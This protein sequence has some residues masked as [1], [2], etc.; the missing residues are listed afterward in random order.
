MP[1]LASRRPL[2]RSS[3]NRFQLQAAAEALAAAADRRD[4][5]AASE[6]LRRLDALRREGHARYK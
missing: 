5:A 6:A 3:L 1:A 4:N 2:A